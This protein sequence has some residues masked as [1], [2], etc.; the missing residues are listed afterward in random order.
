MYAD[1]A[2]AIDGTIPNIGEEADVVQLD[3]LVQILRIAELLRSPWCWPSG[4]FSLKFSLL[5]GEQLTHDRE[6]NL[7]SAGGGGEGN[8][9]CEGN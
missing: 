9:F 4:Y 7:T 8:C 6:K 5:E 1:Q 2:S 3:A